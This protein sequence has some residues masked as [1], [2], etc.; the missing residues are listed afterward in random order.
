MRYLPRLSMLLLLCFTCTFITSCDKDEIAPIASNTIDLSNLDN[1]D[2]DGDAVRI[3][4]QEFFQSNEPAKVTA[5]RLGSI[6]SD[7]NLQIAFK[8]AT[9]HSFEEILWEEGK[10]EES[11]IEKSSAAYKWTGGSRSFSIWC[12]CY[13]Y[14]CIKYTN[15]V[16]NC[17]G[18]SRSGYWRSCRNIDCNVP[19]SC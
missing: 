7:V 12:F 11:E 4:T 13:K 9:E 17:S 2:F 18:Y 15:M 19:S 10:Y 3:Y 5:A 1:I 16:G 6:E 14:P 8:I